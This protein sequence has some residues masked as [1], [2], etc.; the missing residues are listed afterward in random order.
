MKNCQ[1]KKMYDMEIERN[2]VTPRQFFTY[3]CNRM[4]KKD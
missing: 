1:Y 3:C 2:N 4:R